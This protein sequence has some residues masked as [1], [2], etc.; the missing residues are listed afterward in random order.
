MRALLSVYDKTGIVELGRALHELGWEIVSTGGTHRT[1]DAAGVPVTA[2]SAITG[3]P[4]IL[5][6]RVKTL[7]PKIHGGLLGRRSLAEH[8]SQM[9]EHEIGAIDL[10]AVNLYPFEATVRDQGTTDDEAIE[11]IDIGGPAMVRAAAKN[12]NDVLVVVDPADYATILAT[13]QEGNAS[14]A[15]R[16]S[17]AAKAFAHT[18]AY[19]ALVAEYLRGPE[20]EET[21]KEQTLSL[22]RALPLRYGENPHQRAAAYRHVTV[23]PQPAG[24]LDAEQLSGKELSFNN[25]LDG[26]AAWKAVRDWNEPAVAIVKH[27]IPCGLAIG[28]TL[29]SA[30]ADALRGDPVS[31]FGGIVAANRAI[32]AETA[33][34]IAETFFE[35]VLAPGFD[36]E[37]LE[38]LRKKKQLRL[39]DMPRPD[40]N[41]PRVTDL[42]FRSITGGFLVQDADDEPDDEAVWNVVT[43]RAPTQAEMTALRFAWKAAR[44]VKSNAIV[45]AGE[46]AVYGVGSGQPNRLESV[47]IAA[48]KA[49]ER[50]SGAVLASDAFFPFRDGLDAAAQ[51]GVSAV[52]Q[53]GGSVR[54][55]EVIA[56]AD[57]HNLA[58]VFTGRRHFLH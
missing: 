4:E 41:L 51:A 35:I 18:S 58:M 14:T 43:R 8:R 20:A 30:Y 7:H 32:D 42:D 47:A 48:R 9:D 12:H 45:L 29:A 19:D 28:D 10:L 27:T 38:T 33:R 13:L 25:L 21:P 24:I 36:P 37:A 3:F 23:R 49:G 44:H 34:H 56:A 11:Q 50:A 54:D 57:E 5:D 52:I 17:L 6:G 22:R 2:V 1:L 46:R 31:A 26:D 39:L 15:L 55:D 16:R 53:P 40:D